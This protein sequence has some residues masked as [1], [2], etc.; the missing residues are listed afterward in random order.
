MRE[1]RA[2]VPR[3]APPLDPAPA[4]PPDPTPTSDSA[5]APLPDL[6]LRR[7]EGGSSDKRAD[8]Q[9]AAAPWP[10]LTSSRDGGSRCGEDGGALNLHRG[11]GRTAP[12]G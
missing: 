11:G 10:L 1:T 2:V 6:H 8:H 5:P 12:G 9:H 7:K 4:P 3:P